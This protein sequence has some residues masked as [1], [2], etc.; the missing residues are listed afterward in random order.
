[1]QSQPQ[2][3]IAIV[4]L[5]CQ[6]PGDA[7]DPSKFWDM[8]KSGRDGYTTKTDRYNEE[9]FHHTGGDNKRQN[10]LPVKAAEAIA[11]DPKQRIVVEVAYEA[12]ENARMSLRGVA[13]TQAAC[14]IGT[15]M[16]DY[17]DSVV[18][19]FGNYPKYHLLGTGDEVISN[20]LSHFLDIHGPS[21]TI[22]TAC[23]SSHVAIHLAC[24]SLR[25]GEY[26]MAIAGGVG[27]TLVPEST[28]QLN[29]LGFLSPLGQSR[30]FDSKVGGVIVMKR[31]DKAVADGDM[32]RAIICGSGYVYESNGLDYAGDP[33]EASAVYRDI[34]CNKLWI[35]SVKPNIGYYD[36]TARYPLAVLSPKGY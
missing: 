7:T 34:T 2:G 16:S 29:N 22:E 25:T 20:R 36:V 15:S 26:E 21:A 33:T 35:G 12:L 8:L 9:T 6:F 18:R 27:M 30:A 1:M 3:P 10:V 13:G 23:S 19:D 5:S 32:I 14:Y 31:L 4:G 24:Q 28:M 17:R 11:F